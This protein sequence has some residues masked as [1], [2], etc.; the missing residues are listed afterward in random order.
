MIGVDIVE[1]NLQA[2]RKLAESHGVSSNCEF[3]MTPSE[4]ADVI[5]SMDA[6]EHFSDPPAILKK[7]REYVKDDGY[8]LVTFGYTWLH[9]LGGHLFSVFPWA[10]LV[11]TE[12]ALIRWR[13]E[14]KDDGAL[15]FGEV[16]GGLNR[17]TIRRWEKI[18]A[19]SPFEIEWQQVRPIRAFRWFHN[20]L[21]REFFTSTLQMK[22]VPRRLSA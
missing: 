1:K 22:L 4:K 3:V 15:H 20:R 17:M 6:F 19:E 13:S 21:T 10:H 18:V 12:A 5:L 14:F 7:M 2:A 8:A 9:P 11:F 16:S